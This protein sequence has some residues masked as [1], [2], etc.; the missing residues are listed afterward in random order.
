MK[1]L[2]EEFMF[3]SLLPLYRIFMGKKAYAHEAADV[4]KI[5]AEKVGKIHAFKDLKIKNAT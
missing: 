5:K 2:V 3:I 4:E 1:P